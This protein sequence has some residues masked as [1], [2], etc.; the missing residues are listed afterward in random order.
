MTLAHRL[1]DALVAA[2]TVGRYLDRHYRDTFDRLARPPIVTAVQAV[3]NRRRPRETVGLAEERIL[4]GEQEATRTIVRDQGAFMRTTYANSTAER[5][6]NTKT[7]GVVRGSFE[8]LADLP[9]R[10]RHGVFAAPRSF[11]A[12]VRF[13][14]PGRSRRPTCATTG[15]SASG[16]S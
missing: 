11:P 16:S 6:G 1:H 8:V 12:W 13:G 15:C 14:G 4:P 10:V 7:Y 5:V 2:N 9:E 3:I